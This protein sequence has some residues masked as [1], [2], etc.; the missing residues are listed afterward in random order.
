MIHQPCAEQEGALGRS[1]ALQQDP[2]ETE[3]LTF[4]DHQQV[5][6]VFKGHVYRCD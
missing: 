6:N 3:I 5:W 2:A 1:N 4:K